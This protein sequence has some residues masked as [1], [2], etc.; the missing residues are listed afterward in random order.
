MIS[1]NDEAHLTEI[2][3]NSVKIKAGDSES[4]KIA[5]EQVE[6]AKEELANYIKEGGD[7]HSFLKFYHDKLKEAH[8]V[9]K[10]AQISALKVCREEPDIAVAFIK[11]IN[12]SLDKKGIK[13]LSIP[14]GLKQL[15]GYNDEK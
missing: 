14:P 8:M 2:I 4:I 11:E 3:M 10:D 6:L 15:I 9:W 1:I 5:K 13:R 7:I 12:E